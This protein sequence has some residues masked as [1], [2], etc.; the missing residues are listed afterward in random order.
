MEY[1]TTLISKIKECK[2]SS[3]LITDIL[4][5]NKDIFEDI[6]VEEVLKKYNPYIIYAVSV[7]IEKIEVFLLK[8]VIYIEIYDLFVMAL[9]ANNYIDVLLLFIKN[10]NKEIVRYFIENN[11]PFSDVHIENSTINETFIIFLSQNIIITQK[12]INLCILNN[13]M[14]VIKYLNDNKIYSFNES[15]LDVAC[16]SNSSFI[17]E[18]FISLKIKSQNA[19]LYCVK[20]KNHELLEFLLKKNF[21]T[22]IESLHNAV[23]NNDLTSVK[24]LLK[25]KKFNLNTAISLSKNNS[26]IEKFL[27]SKNSYCL[28]I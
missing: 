21:T 1:N 25:Y 14:I 19:I 13:N 9:D 3:Y 24:I 22:D 27:I 8:A 5:K 7:I 10:N 23:L 12:L 28:L 11:F 17:I 4:I 15:D 2:I 20:S 16:L 18:Y 6:L 26:E